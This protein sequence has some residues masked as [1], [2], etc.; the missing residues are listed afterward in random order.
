M[1]I[2]LLGIESSC[3]DTSA[4]I[5]KDGEILS[6]CVANQEVHKLYGGVVPEVA[7]R[8]HQV[9]IIPVVDQAIKKAGIQKSDISA[10]AFTRGPGLIGSL[11]TRTLQ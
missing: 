9:N 8:A 10:V 2:V 11:H 7:S 4:S 6:N 5:L 3:D 1:S